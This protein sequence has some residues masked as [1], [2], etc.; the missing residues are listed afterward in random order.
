MSRRRS[1]PKLADVTSIRSREAVASHARLGWIAGVGEGGDPLVDFEGN[2][3]PLPAASILSAS[4][5][6]YERAAIDRRPVVLLFDH[7]DALRPIVIGFVVPPGP[8]DVQ[9]DRARSTEAR[10][11]ARVDGERV[12]LEGK[13]EVVLTCGKA[14]ITLRRNGRVVIRGAYVESHSGGT[15]RIKGCIVSIN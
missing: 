10:A 14:S 8:R 9:V 2:A 3:R 13:D 1:T 12:L 11:V 5:A 15:N 4:R 6:D 7:G